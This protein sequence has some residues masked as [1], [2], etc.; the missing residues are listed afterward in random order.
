M[1]RRKGETTGAMNER[2]FPEMVELALPPGGFSDQVS[3]SFTASTAFRFDPADLAGVAQMPPPSTRGKR[4]FCI[5]R[6]TSS[7]MSSPIIISRSPASNASCLISSWVR[8]NLF[9]RSSP[10]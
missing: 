7:L 1:R 9:V 10:L 3:G 6:V 4:F 2:D 5:T 8:A